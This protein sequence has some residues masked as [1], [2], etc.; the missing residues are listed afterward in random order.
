MLPQN[1]DLS[2]INPLLINTDSIKSIRSKF[3]NASQY[4]ES[5]KELMEE[6][7][8]IKT[9]DQDVIAFSPM[10]NGTDFIITSLVAR[11]PDFI[12]ANGYIGNKFS[13]ILSSIHQF[14]ICYSI[15][16]K[17]NMNYTIGFHP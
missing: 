10:A 8:K 4:V 16:P 12:L 17:S 1:I 15:V 5:L 6:I 3:E 9:A 14:Q 2:K 7:S 13:L 11:N